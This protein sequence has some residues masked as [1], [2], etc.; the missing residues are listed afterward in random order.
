VAVSKTKPAADVIEAYNGGQRHFGENYI[1]ELDEKSR[2]LEILELC[3]DIQ[4]HF[5]G[6][7]QRN[8][9]NKLISLP[10]LHMV[11][12]VDSAKLA[13]AL[14]SSWAK[15]QKPN[16]LKTLIQV[17]T[18]GEESKSGISPSEAVALSK[19]IIENCP[20]LE[21]SGLMTIGAYDYDVTLGPNPDF[22]RLVECHKEVCNTLGLQPETFELSMGMSSDYQH[23]I[24]LGSTNVRIGSTIFGPRASKH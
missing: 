7:L 14:N 24:E 3:P 9:V 10:G 11:E 2:N 22:L 13:D 6:H 18:S 19:H 4:W 23:A 15:L 5:I 16:Q 21:L 17:N 20:N 8:K 12:T 1:Q